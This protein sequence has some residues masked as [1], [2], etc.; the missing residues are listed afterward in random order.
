MKKLLSNKIVNFCFFLALSI[1]LIY[2]AFRSV[3]FKHIIQG[4]KNVNY[5]WVV[6]S[7]VAALTAHI[8]RAYRWGI[9]IEPLGK[10]V[11]FDNLFSAVMIGYFANIAFPRLGEVAKCGSVSK[12]DGI[13]IESLLGTV[14]AERGMD[15]VMLIVSTII[16]FFI[17]IEVFGNFILTHILI[18]IKEKA[19]KVHPYQII[20]LLIII[21]AFVVIVRIVLKNNLLGEKLNG[22][23]RKTLKGI[24]DG[25]KAVFKSKKKTSFLISSLA[26]WLFYWIMT[27][28]LLKSVPIT[29]NLD[30]FDGLFIMVIGSFGMTIPVQGGFGAYHIITSVALGIFGISYENGLIFAIVSHES[31]TIFLIIAGILALLYLYFKEKHRKKVTE[32]VA[33]HPA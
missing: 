2:Y 8:L 14:V 25:L 19:L 33:N 9:L 24:A 7:L 23:I 16:V 4:F 1:L 18:P 32:Q 5:F 20:I 11:R 21:I 13:R 3:D 31:Q 29:S 27:W 28:L 10:K 22:K 6:L 30:L 15:V 26:I 12:T 17:K